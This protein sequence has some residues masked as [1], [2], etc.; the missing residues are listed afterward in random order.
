MTKR[1]VVLGS[2]GSVGRSVLDVVSHYTEHFEIVGLAARSRTS[3]LREQCA[4]HPGAKFV[5]QDAAAHRRVV[6][7]NPELASRSVSDG[8]EPFV[9]LIEETKPDLLVNCLVGFVGLKPTLAALEIGVPVALAN[10]EAIVT[11]GELVINA[12]KR[13]GA[14]VIPI[15]S[16][17]VAISQC[18]KGSQTADVKKVYLTA[19]GGALRDRAPEEMSDVRVEDVLDHPTWNMGNKITVDSATLLNKG[20]EVIE[21]HW[22]FD[23]PLETIEVVIHPQSIIHCL[24]EFKDNSILAQMGFPDMRLPVLYALT[25]PDRVATDLAPSVVTD[26]PELTLTRVDERRYPCLSLALRAAENG[27]NVPAI[28]NSANEIAVGAFLASKIPFSKIYEIIETAVNH[29]PPSEIRSFEDVL[30]ADRATRAY[31]KEEFGL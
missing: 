17:H 23:L 16:E 10:K 8:R 3:L 1:I 4:A 29:I 24:V 5:V 15:D 7:D 11:G 2:T 19:S 9:R 22:L 13:S 25:Y 21:A 18:L 20:F 31:I 28:L 6:E 27:G 14:P 26:F 12:S 30:E